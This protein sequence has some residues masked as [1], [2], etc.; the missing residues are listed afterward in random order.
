L[1]TFSR[2]VNARARRIAD[3]VAS[4]PE[5]TKRTIS[6]AGMYSITHRARS[7]SSGLGAP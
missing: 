2:L 7:S 6:I 3:M 4:V 5:L 1:T